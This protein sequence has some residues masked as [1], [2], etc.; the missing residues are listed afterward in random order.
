MWALTLLSVA[1]AAQYVSPPTWW[2][3]GPKGAEAAV[4]IF[5]TI[6]I[7]GVLNIYMR[8]FRHFRPQTVL[9]ARIVNEQIKYTATW[10]NGAA[11]AVLATVGISQ[12]LPNSLLG[13]EAVVM[14]MF[15][16]FFLARFARD[17]VALIKSEDI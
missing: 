14:G 13:R 12:S 10:L 4:I 5:V 3:G 2:P 16:V 8:A 6:G 17:F 9:E 7:V 1:L 11:V 15:Y